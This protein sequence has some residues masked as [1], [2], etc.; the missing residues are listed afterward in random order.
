MKNDHGFILAY[1]VIMI[2]ILCMFVMVV[3]S[4]G[5]NHAK[6]A[7]A[8]QD[9]NAALYVAESGINQ[10]LYRIENGE[11]VLPESEEEGED[12]DVDVLIDEFSHSTDFFTDGSSYS[13]E[14]Y[15]NAADKLV[16]IESEARKEEEQER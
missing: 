15:Y 4:L 5:M 16:T 14:I 8:L 13:V 7:M 12:E 11:T 2:L 10:A 9:R 3:A 1:T 6:N